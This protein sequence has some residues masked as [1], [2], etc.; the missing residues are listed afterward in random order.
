[1]TTRTDPFRELD[2]LA[3]TGTRSRP[4]PLPSNACR[5][6]RARAGFEGNG[7]PARCPQTSA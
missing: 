4:A 3:P 6:A 5:D 2:R 7:A 1:M